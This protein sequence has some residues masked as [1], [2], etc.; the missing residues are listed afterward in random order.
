MEDRLMER[1][2]GAV[3]TVGDHVWA[4]TM[5]A[6]GA[7]LVALGHKDTG[8]LVVGGGLAAFRGQK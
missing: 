4:V 5:I 8:E 7:G 3:N 2:I 6:L 1:V